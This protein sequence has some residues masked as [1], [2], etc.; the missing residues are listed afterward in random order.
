[1]PT[2]NFITPRGVRH[3]VPADTGESLMDAAI[4]YGLEE[5]YAECG[6]MCSC[7]TCHCFIDE[8]WLPKLDPPDELEDAMLDCVP[9]RRPTSRLSC[10][11]LITEDLDGLV[12]GLPAEQ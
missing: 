6:G 11:I 1:M 8:S 7:A 5:I 2:V 12:V 4:N 3:E 9:D 10:Q